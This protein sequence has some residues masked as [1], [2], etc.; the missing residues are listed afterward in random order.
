M[1]PLR[2]IANAQV[3]RAQALRGEASTELALLLHRAMSPRDVRKALMKERPVLDHLRYLTTDGPD[4]GV[5]RDAAMRSGILDCDEGDLAFRSLYPGLDVG[6]YCANHA[7]GKPSEPTRLALEQYYVQHAIYGSDAFIYAG[8]LNHIDDA[9]HLVGELCGDAELEQGDVAFFPS[10]SDALSA[11]LSSHRGRLVTTEGHFT[12]AHYI[13]QHWAK[14]T[15]GEVVIVEQDDQECIEASRIIEALTPDTTVVSLSLVHWR[16]GWVH[17]MEPVIEAMLS[18]CP[19]A[20]LLLDVYQGHGTVPTRFDQLPLK[21]A[22]LG[23][24][25]KQLHGGLGAAYAW[26]TNALLETHIPDRLG[27]FAHRDPM[28]FD[29]EFVPGDG[30]QRLHTGP[31]LVLP[32]SLLSTELKVLASSG[33]DGSVTSGVARA[34]HVTS[35]LV[36]YGIEIARNRGMT[37]RGP[38]E[39]GRRGAFF[40]IE[41]DDGPFILDGLTAAGVTV[42]FRPDVAGGSAGLLRVSASAA[43][44]PYEMEFAVDTIARLTGRL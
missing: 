32:I 12:T 7:V 20:T 4:P 21:T 34:R 26:C 9:R 3:E 35:A 29:P 8:W 42:D 22:M 27:W 25:L 37:I 33:F 40:A 5:L 30:P 10:L 11:V 39:P 24:A 31:P 18:I 6:V 16:S 23:G 28:A 17:E 1:D 41:V 15:G 2:E 19:E 14:Q 44:F 43:H 38:D 36:A 13:H